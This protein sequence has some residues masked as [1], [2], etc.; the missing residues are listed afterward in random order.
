MLM[1]AN[2]ST[3][4]IFLEVQWPL[5]SYILLTPP[6]GCTS[7][8]L[9]SVPTSTPPA[10]TVKMTLKERHDIQLNNTWRK[11]KSKTN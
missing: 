3:I 9:V 8:A 4:A 7:T 2:C 6:G 1:F 5:K 11:C 10:A